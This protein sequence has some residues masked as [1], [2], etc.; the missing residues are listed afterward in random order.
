MDK[1]N[2]NVYVAYLKVLNE[3]SQINLKKDY[4]I[5]ENFSRLNSVWISYDNNAFKDTIKI[6]VYKTI[7]GYKEFITDVDI[8]VLKFK[9]S[10][11]DFHK[12][13]KLTKECPY[14]ILS[15]MELVNLDAIKSYLEKNL[16]PERYEVVENYNNNTLLKKY[17]LEKLNRIFNAAWDTYNKL[18]EQ[19]GYSSEKAR[20][21]CEKNKDK[22]KRKELKKQYEELWR[23]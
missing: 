17:Y 14:F 19:G 3:D 12:E 1:F 20:K 5:S 18:L 10:T 6:L 13:Y 4:T 11:S 15:N 7:F 23:G 9:N 2:K 8:P 16:N 21:R 22:E